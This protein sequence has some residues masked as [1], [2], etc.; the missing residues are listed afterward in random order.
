MNEPNSQRP[1]RRIR[2]RGKNPRNFDEKYKELNPDQ[3]PSEVAK[4]TAR[5]NTPA[6]THRPIMV[7]E[8][9]QAL[10]PVS[11]DIAVDCTLGFGGHSMVMLAAI[12]PNGRLIAFDA[13]P[14]ELPKTEARLR[15]LGYSE[16]SIWLSRTNFAS[17]S[18]VLGSAAPSG[19]Q[20]IFADLGVSSMQIDD[21]VRGFSYR[22]DGPLDM[23]MNPARGPSA[24]QLLSTL[25]VAA[26][27][28]LLS[29]NSD[30]P[31]AL[32]LAVGILKAHAQAPIASTFELARVVRQ[33]MTNI[34]SKE[35]DAATDSVRRVFQSLRIAVNDEFGVLD[36]LLR[37]I[38]NCL[39][40]G[41]RAAILSFHSGE[42]RRVKHAF[43]AGLLSGCYSKVAEHCIR[44]SMQEQREN[45]RSTSAK[46]RFA[47]RA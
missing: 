45:P 16:E 21:P 4:V 33:F 46:L 39:A 40:P 36:S 7:A 31:N 18:A 3:Y 42:D 30:E 28:S 43:H 6:G 13:D 25:D 11:G 9:M 14:I 38:P 44:P 2:Y 32:G 17:I 23:R 10:A 27:S 41:G 29:I 5:G 19:V 8:V 20:L 24:S 26:L 37:Q 35:V 22:H 34:K 47:F 1:N 15:S 12:Q